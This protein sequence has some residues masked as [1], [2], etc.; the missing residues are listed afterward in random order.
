MSLSYVISLVTASVLIGSVI[1]LLAWKGR[2]KGFSR[3]NWVGV[4]L[5]AVIFAIMLS[6]A[7][8]AVPS[9]SWSR[10]TTSQV[11]PNG[12]LPPGQDTYVALPD[13]TY[14][15]I[16]ADA[17]QD[18]LAGLKAKLRSDFPQAA[19]PFQYVKLPDGSYGK[20]RADATDAAI[21]AAIEKDFPGAYKTLAEHER[22]E[23]RAARWPKVL[24]FI[25]GSRAVP[26]SIRPPACPEEWSQTDRSPSVVNAARAIR[27]R[28]THP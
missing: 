26:H 17:T 22:A 16:P 24:H 25:A 3:L 9:D 13:G 10:D 4:A 5:G 15:R 27:V 7:V 12:N 21:R 1:P 8:A 28:G 18:Q 11:M 2:P 14:V 6:V 23:R 19:A 20:F